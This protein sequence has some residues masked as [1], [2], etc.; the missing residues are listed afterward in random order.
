MMKKKMM[1]MLCS[2]NAMLPKIT[3]TKKVKEEAMVNQMKEEE[4]HMESKTTIE[5]EIV[6]QKIRKR[7]SRMLLICQSVIA[8]I[9]ASS[10]ARTLL[11]MPSVSVVTTQFAGIVV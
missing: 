1:K 3:G 10:A 11:T 6:Q 4:V 9:N 5:E 8:M 7:T 2:I